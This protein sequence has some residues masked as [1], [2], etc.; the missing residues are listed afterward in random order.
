MWELPFVE[1]GFCPVFFSWIILIHCVKNECDAKK[2]RRKRPELSNE[3]KNGKKSYLHLHI[4]IYTCSTRYMYIQGS[5][6]SLGFD[7]KAQILL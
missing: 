6:Y 3:L 1:D 4:N 5:S 7:D 2:K